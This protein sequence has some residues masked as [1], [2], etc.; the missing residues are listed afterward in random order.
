[1]L[2]SGKTTYESLGSVFVKGDADFFKGPFLFY[3]GL[4][5]AAT[6]VND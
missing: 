6:A 2:V 5:E 3:L 4:S 1:M